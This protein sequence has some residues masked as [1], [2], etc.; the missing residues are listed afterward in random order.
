MPVTI[1]RLGPPR[2]TPAPSR[3]NTQNSRKCSRLSPSVGH[4]CSGLDGLGLARRAR[5]SPL[6]SGASRRLR[7]RWRPGQLREHSAHRERDAQL[8]RPVE[9]GGLGDER[10][11]TNVPRE[12]GEQQLAASPAVEWREVVPERGAYEAFL[13]LSVAECRRETR[14]ELSEAALDL[15]GP[16][17]LAIAAERAAAVVARRRWAERAHRHVRG[18][19]HRFSAER[20]LEVPRSTNGSSSAAS[21]RT[22]VLRAVRRPPMAPP[23]RSKSSAETRASW[24]L[25]APSGCRP[26]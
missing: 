19:D 8:G 7:N 20:T 22:G 18:R 15:G 10:P 5:R 13:S 4:L 1:T 25:G 14:E 3:S 16:E 9:L 11:C 6:R 12:E 21:L 23:A 17:R 26:M 24:S 2:P